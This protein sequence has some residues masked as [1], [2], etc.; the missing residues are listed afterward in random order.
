MQADICKTTALSIRNRTLDYMLA[1]RPEFEAVFATGPRSVDALDSAPALNLDLYC[2]CMRS[3]V[4]QGD[5][6]SVKAAALS[7][8]MEIRVLTYDAKGDAIQVLSYSGTPVTNE[9]EEPLRDRGSLQS[10]DRNVVR[11]NPGGPMYRPVAEGGQQH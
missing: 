4:D 1:H 8:G 10:F 11:G 3:E 2:Q 7:L 5:E 9:S 6:L